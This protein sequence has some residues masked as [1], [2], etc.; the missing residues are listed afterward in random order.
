MVRRR[1]R[2]GGAPRTRE[3]LAPAPT[4]ESA[5]TPSAIEE[6]DDAADADDLEYFRGPPASDPG[7][8]T[9]S[10]RRYR[11]LR[12]LG[13]LPWVLLARLFG[14]STVKE[15]A[16]HLQVADTRAAIVASCT[17]LLVAS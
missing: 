17:P 9:L 2:R 16:E 7:R 14:R 15:L 10:R 8:L 1:P 5:E 4:E 13:G 12:G 3:P 6:H 11:K